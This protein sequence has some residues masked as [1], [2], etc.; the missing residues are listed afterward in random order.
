MSGKNA[1][2]GNA[3]VEQKKKKHNEISSEKH[4]WFLRGQFN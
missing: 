4:F 3:P 1:V 2:T